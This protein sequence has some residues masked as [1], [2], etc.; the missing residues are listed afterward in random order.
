M[1]FVQRKFTEWA[2][3]SSS[4]S[5]RL[6]IEC[7][8]QA[9]SNLHSSYIPEGPAQG[10]FCRIWNWSAYIYICTQ[11][12]SAETQSPAYWNLIGPRMTASPPLLSPSSILPPSMSHF[13][14]I[15]AKKNLGRAKQIFFQSSCDRLQNCEISFSRSVCPFVLPSVRMEQL[16]SH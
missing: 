1:N 11:G 10:D 14:F 8:L 6:D 13:T 16:G 9:L 15:P 3:F 2:F 12:S 4:K 5:L 7:I